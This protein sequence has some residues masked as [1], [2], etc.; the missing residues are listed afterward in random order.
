MA[1]SHRSGRLLRRI[2]PVA[3]LAFATL[4]LSGCYYPYG[5]PAYGY[6]GYAY[7]PVAVAPIVVGGGYY[8][9]GWGGYR[10]W[11]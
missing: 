6:P 10:G 1:I 11:R 4:G 3:A 7:A 8:G 2:I 9:R 5:Y